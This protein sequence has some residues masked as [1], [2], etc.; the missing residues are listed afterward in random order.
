MAFEAII[1]QQTARPSNWRRITFIVSIAL[2]AV[3][4]A[5]GVVHSL[6]QV[7]ELPMPAVEVTLAV[8]APP[9]PPPP[10][11]KRASK[12]PK[13]KPTEPK[14]QTLVAPKEAPKAEPEPEQAEEAS[15]DDEEGDDNGQEGGVI[16]GV[17]GGVVG[18]TA[19][20][21]PKN[22]GPALLTNR[23]GHGL[24]AINPN[25]APYKVNVPERYVR[26]GTEYAAQ[27]QVCVG[28]N[29]AVRSVRITRPTIPPIDQQLMK[30][31]PKWRY[32][33]HLVNGVPTEF[34]YPV[35][36]LVK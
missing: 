18:G 36:Y 9:P 28:T 16:G 17:V 22:T 26:M 15:D 11:P 29:G 4:L 12:K 24:L 21:P 5:A 35:R 3:L 32:K 13:T 19:P 31:V 10:P 27:L 8:A 20:P 34:C 6:W 23:Q 7:D 1:L 30:V 25:V 2:H 14:P 33:V